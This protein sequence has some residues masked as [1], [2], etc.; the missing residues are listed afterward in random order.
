MWFHHLLLRND[1]DR[2][3]SHSKQSTALPFLHMGNANSLYLGLRRV[4]HWVF[5]IA[6]VRTPILG[7][8]ILQHYDLLVK[9]GGKRLTDS[10]TQL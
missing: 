1:T 3:V 2:K 7:A 9:L 10:L 8:D 6:D 5:I 4:F